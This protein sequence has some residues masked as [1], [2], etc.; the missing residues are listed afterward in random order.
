MRL[1]RASKYYKCG[2]CGREIVV[3]FGYVID[4][5]LLLHSLMGIVW[6]VCTIILFW[7]IV[8]ISKDIQYDKLSDKEPKFY[9]KIM[10]GTPFKKDSDGKLVL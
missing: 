10:E 3:L 9:E 4:C 2:A 5:R 6:I 8:L 1:I 7:I